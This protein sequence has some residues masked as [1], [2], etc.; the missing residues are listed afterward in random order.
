MSLTK[1]TIIDQISIDEY[2]SLMI[3]EATKILDDGEEVSRTY[4]RSSIRPGGDLTGQ[5][6]SVVAIANT[7]WTPEV[8]AKYQA[9]QTSIAAARTSQGA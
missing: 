2:G 7:A 9:L 8:L 3:R 4:H 1:E 5:P 6:S